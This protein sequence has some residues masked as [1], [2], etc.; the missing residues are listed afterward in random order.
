[1]EAVMGGDKA[2]QERLQARAD[3]AEA[4]RRALRDEAT[5]QKDVI[6]NL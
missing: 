2:S 3:A 1:M 6:Y 5:D 4:E